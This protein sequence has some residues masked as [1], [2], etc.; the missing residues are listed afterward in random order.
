MDD[1][2]INRELSWLAFDDRVLQLASEPGIPLLERAKFCA[3]TTTNLDE[4][5]QVRVAAPEGPGGRRRRGADGRRPHGHAS[6][7]PRSP[8]G[9][10]SSSPARSR[11][12]STS[13]CRSWPPP[14]I[15][16][17]GWDDLDAVDRKRMTEIYEQRIFPVLTP[18]AVDPS[19]PF[20]YISNLALSVA[21]MVADPDPESDDRR[22][23]RVK[24]PTVFPRLFEVDESRFLPA[25]ELIIA[26]LHTL[27]AGMVIEEAA[28]FRVTRNAD[29]TLEEEEAEDLLEALEMELRR[30]RFN[31]AVRLEVSDSMSD[32][33]LDTARPRAGDRTRPTS[34]AAGPRSTSGSSG[35]STASTAPTSRTGR[36]RRS[37]PGAS[38]SPRR[39]TARWCR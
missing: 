9:P 15:A 31:K 38:P 12:S 23:A 10:A 18:L 22:F 19:H 25:E 2:F 39:P 28:T 37:R 29:L 21:A 6:S 16:I 5:F 8:N 3:I 7:W 4:F 1:R 33:M 17:V 27:F 34:T 11:C 36:G 24:V 13:W 30:R 20:P 32:E 26:H 35:S 14:G